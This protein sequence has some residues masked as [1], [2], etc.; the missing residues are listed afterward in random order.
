MNNTKKITALGFAGLLAVMAPAFAAS[1]HKA[2][3]EKTPSSHS[4]TK[5]LDHSDKKFLTEAAEGGMMEVELGKLAAAQASDPDVKAFGQKMVDDHTKANDKLKQLA[6][7]KGLT[8]PAD[9]GMSEKHMMKEIQ[10]KKGADFDRMYMSAM[11]KDHK[12]DVSDFDHA[13]KSAKD[14]DV[15][16]FASDTLPTLKD[17][18][19]MAQ[20][21]AG[22]IGASTKHATAKKKS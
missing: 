14:S 4:T 9:M 22:K 7:D 13:S 3:T 15:K 21:T 11:V 18:L 10:E 20:T 5:A 19:S 6:A 12:K 8:L 16:A 2:T 17:H 1:A